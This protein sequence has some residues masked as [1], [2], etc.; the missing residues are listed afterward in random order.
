MR[1]KILELGAKMYLLKVDN[2]NKKVIDIF[3]KKKVLN[4]LTISDKIKNTHG[5]GCTLSSAVWTFVSWKTSKEILWAWYY[6]KFAIKSNPKWKGHGPINHL[7]SI[8][9]KLSLDNEN[10]VVVGSQQGRR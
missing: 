10:I 2:L 7:T 8:K 6:V 3:I 4:F 9:V 5:T 1:H